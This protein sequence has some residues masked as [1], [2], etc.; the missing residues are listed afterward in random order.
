MPTQLEARNTLL[1]TFRT[2]F[3]ALYSP[4]E[5][6]WTHDN[7]T[8]DGGGRSIWIDLGIRQTASIQRTLGKPGNRRYRREGVLTVT[9]RTL[10]GSGLAKITEIAQAIRG[11]FEGTKIEGINPVG[12]VLVEEQ[13]RDITGYS[14]IVSVPFWY[15]ERG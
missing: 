14:V 1:S 10:P 12:G 2:R 7:L 6:P 5:I 11:I 9:I 8:F 15:E 13:G 4:Q 3:K